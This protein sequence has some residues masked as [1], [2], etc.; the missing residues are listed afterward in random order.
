[1]NNWAY[2][3][4]LEEKDLEH[5]LAMAERVAALTQ[6]NPTYMDTHAWVLFKMGRLEEARQLLRKAIALDGQK[7][8]ELLVHY[9]EEYIFFLYCFHLRIFDC[10][11][12]FRQ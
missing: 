2:F 5:A 3:L 4:S 7:S 11:L 10:Q 6:N 8:V 1:M 9:G 12:Y